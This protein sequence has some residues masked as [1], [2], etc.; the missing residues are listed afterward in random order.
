MP[1]KQREEDKFGPTPYRPYRSCNLNT[2]KS[3]ISN[4]DK[5]RE[6]ITENVKCNNT[7]NSF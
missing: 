6:I 3:K 1:D 4:K 7:K 5:N 2:E